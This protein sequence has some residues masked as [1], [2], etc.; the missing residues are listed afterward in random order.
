M[1]AWKLKGCPR[2]LGDLHILRDDVGWFEDCLQCGYRRYLK[3]HAAV[4]ARKASRDESENTVKS[5]SSRSVNRP[6]RLK[7][8]ARTTMISRN[9]RKRAEAAAAK[10][11]DKMEKLMLSLRSVLKRPIEII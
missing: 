4:S 2:C 11:Q 8:E 7:A 1:T 5:E 3:M 6:V 9:N 10:P